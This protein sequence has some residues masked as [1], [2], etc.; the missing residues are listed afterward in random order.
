MGE[1]PQAPPQGRILSTRPTKKAGR[2]NVGQAGGT[3]FLSGSRD[4]VGDPQKGQP[5]VRVVVNGI[6]RG[7]VFIARLADGAEHGQ[8]FA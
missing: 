6:G 2:Q 7:R 5:S 1:F 3:D 4:V 8:P